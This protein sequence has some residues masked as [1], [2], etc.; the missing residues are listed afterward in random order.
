MITATVGGNVGSVELRATPDGKPILS[1]SVA[2]NERV[3]GEEQTT[4]V[5]CSMFSDRGAA[6]SNVLVKGSSVM[7]S[8]SLTLREYESQGVKRTSLDMRVDNLA[9]IGGKRDGDRAEHDAA[10][11]APRS[12]AQPNTRAAAPAPASHGRST[13][14]VTYPGVKSAGDFEIRFGSDKGKRMSQIDNLDNLR[15]FIIKGVEDPTRAQYADKGKA[16]VNAIDEEIAKRASGGA[17]VEDAAYGESG[18]GGG[19]DAD[20]PFGSCD[21]AHEQPWAQHKPRRFGMI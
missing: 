17:P 14:G 8:G 20:I 12:A 18:Y 11:P 5:R 6:L 2:S 9:F 13:G 7:V 3:K 1:F 21:A 19:S 16:Q 4:W 15:S 10:P